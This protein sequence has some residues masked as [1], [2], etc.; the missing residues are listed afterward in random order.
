MIRIF[1]IMIFCL[2]TF[3]LCSGQEKQAQKLLSEAI[4]MEVVNGKLD[5]AIKAYQVVL[6][7]FPDEREVAAE[8]LFHLG[9]C[10]E[11]L[12]TRDAVNTYKQLVSNYPDQKNF[13]AQAR[14]RLNRL[15]ALAEN[16]LKAPL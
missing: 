10:Y 3:I 9:M 7:Q 14:N 1:I 13:G 2:G 15:I 5:E 6:K 8:A 12:G 4:Y 11:K 16:E